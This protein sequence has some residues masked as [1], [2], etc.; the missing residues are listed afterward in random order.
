MGFLSMIIDKAGNL[1]GG[2]ALPTSTHVSPVDGAV[3][4]T[5]NVTVTCSGFPFTVDDANCVISYL[6]YKPTGGTWQNMLVN[7]QNGVS[8]VAAANVLTVAGAG[9]PF[10]AGDSYRVG[11]RYQD[12]GYVA[13]TNDSRVSV[14]N[15]L[16]TF[17]TGP[18]DIYAAAD[19]TLTNA[20]QD[21][22]GEIATTGFK[23]G[24]FMIDKTFGAGDAGLLLQILGKHTGAGAAEYVIET[25]IALGDASGSIAIVRSALTGNCFEYIQLQ[26]KATTAGNGSKVLKESKYELAY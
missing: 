7:G 1:L 13:V 20:Y 4:Y 21:W 25:D 9:T 15:G 18:Q 12:K 11:I 26:V 8:I 24:A 5:S 16:N 19:L 14:T 2:S 3:A 22:G 23:G 6:L 17:R 10:A